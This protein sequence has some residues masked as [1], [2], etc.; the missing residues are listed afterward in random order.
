MKVA[1]HNL[2]SSSSSWSLP[3]VGRLKCNVDATIMANGM[4]FGAVIRDHSGSFVAAYDGLLRSKLDPYMA[5][6]LAIK[7][8]LTCLKQRHM[9]HIILET[10][11]L[12]FCTNYNSESVDLS[13]VGLLLKHGKVL[14]RDIVDVVV[15]HVQ[16]SANHMVHA[17]MRATVS[18][19]V[20]GVWDIIPPDCISGLL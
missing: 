8:A 9:S 13:Y 6:T 17:L 15:C 5:E 16:R 10:D 19:S 12:N 4:G 20:L 14:A 11:C 1:S 7:E 3:P 18:S 2:P